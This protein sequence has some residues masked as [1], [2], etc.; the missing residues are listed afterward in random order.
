MLDILSEAT[1]GSL[2]SLKQIAL[3]VIPL[4]TA[5]E[6]LKDLK[7]LDKIASL[8]SPIVKVYGMKKES[9]LPIVVGLLIGLAYG[10]G[11]IMRSAQ[12][13]NLSKRDLYLI[14]Y[15][16]VSAH[17]VFED[18]LV[19]VAIGASGTLLLTTRIFVAALFTF[20]ASRLIE[21]DFI[22]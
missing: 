20:L 4:M 1:V 3:V 22:Q 14:T 2:M 5:I 10:A 21:R 13:D 15:F 18:T 8:F 6:I 19:F 11:V 12:E 9:G 7:V 17:S 16:L